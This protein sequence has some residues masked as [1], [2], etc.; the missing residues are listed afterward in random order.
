MDKIALIGLGAITKHYYKGLTGTSAF[1]LVAVCDKNENAAARELFKAFPFYD[2]YEEMIQRE[3]PDFVM[4]AT[5]PATHAK[6]ARRALE[7]GVNVL[8]EKPAATSFDDLKALLDEGKKKG[9][10]CE[11]AFHWQT[12]E[13]VVRFNELFKGD[14]PSRVFVEVHD[15]YAADG[16]IRE[17]RLPLDGAWLDSGVN[18]LSLV[19]TWLPFE[20]VEI[21]SLVCQKCLKSGLPLY[22]DVKLCIDGAD[23]EIVVDWRERKNLKRSDLT[24]NGEEIAIEHSAQAIVTKDKTLRFDD[25]E[26]LDRHYYNYFTRY[27]KADNQ[28][29]TL[30]IHEILFKVS[31]LL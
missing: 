3:K 28:S 14:K 12:G 2:D 17:D 25:M 24:V 15:D 5:P 19:H 26:R 16:F 30:K 4:I 22:C 27:R 9:L 18:A 21:R 10:T 1:Q 7:L 29:A 8:M 31:E 11:I 6:I 20:K 23:V 13:E